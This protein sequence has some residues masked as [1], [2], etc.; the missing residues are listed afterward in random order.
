MVE[1]LGSPDKK[2]QAR[3]FMLTRYSATTVPMRWLSQ[4]TDQTVGSSTRRFTNTSGTPWRPHSSD[5]CEDSR[6][7]VTTTASTWYCNS[8]G[9]SS[10]ASPPG[11]TTKSSSCR[12]VRRSCSENSSRAVG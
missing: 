9:I 6:A 10:S 2:A 11:G 7:A 12:P 4:H 5:M 1:I 3:R 8:S